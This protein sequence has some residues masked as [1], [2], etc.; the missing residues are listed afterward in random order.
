MDSHNNRKVFV[1]KSKIKKDALFLIDG[2]YFLYRSYFALPPLHTPDGKPTHATYAFCRTLNKIIKEYDPQQIA[3]VWDSKG[4]TQRK[5]EYEAYK[6]TR[7]EPPSDLFIQ[8]EDIIKFIELIN[9][10]S[11][12]KTGYEADDLIAS[13]AKENKDKQTV[14]I[15]ADKDMSQLL[16]DK[17]ILIID[18]FKDR[19]IDAQELKQEKGFDPE[20]VPF[21]FSLLGDSSDNIPGVKGVGKKTALDLVTQF[22]S[23]DDLYKNL[24]KIEK[25]RTQTLLED[26]KDNAYLS[27]KLFLLHTIKLGIKK[28]ELDFDKNNLAKA[29]NFF[30]DLGFKSLVKE[31]EKKH[32]KIQEL[33]QQEIFEKTKSNNWKLHVVTNTLELK[34][35][36]AQLKKDK[37][38]ALDT[39]TTGVNPLVHTLVGLS[40]ASNTK[41][42]FYVPLAHPKSERYA[43]VKFKE[44]LELLK[45]LFESKTI[46]KTLHH[47]KFDELVLYQY[48]IE[49]QG[50]DFDTIIAA[51]LLRQAWQK[52][53]LKDLSQKYLK[54]PMVKFKDIVKKKYKTFAEV[55]IEDGAEYGAHDALQ[56]L[57][58]KKVLEKDFE[59]EPALKKLFKTI[60]MPFHEVLLAMEKKGILLDPEILNATGEKITHK[61]KN[62]ETKIFAALPIGKQKISGKTINLNSPKQIEI[63]LF[64]YL[65]LPAP[66]ESA[67]GSR[68]TDREVLLELGKQHP[69]PNLIV[70]YRELAK[71]KN[72]YIDPLPKAINKK[73]KRIHTSF[74]QTMTATGRLSSSDPNLQNIPAYGDYGVAIREA[75]V[76]SHGYEFVSADYSQMQ[77]RI[78]AHMSG[79]KN[80]TNAF[81][82]NKD[83]H[84]QTAS[85]IFNIPEE[86]VT[87]EQR[88][89]GK[90]INFSVIY[91][92]TPYGLSKE[93]QVKP[94]VAKEFIQAYFE[95][96]PNVAQWIEKTIKTTEEHGYVESLWGRRRW[97][98]EIKEKNRARY[99]LG[100]RLA[101]NTPVQATEAD[102]MKIA[103]LNITQALHKEKLK[104]S[105]VLQIHDELILE[106][107]T[108][109]ISI[110]KKML[111][112]EMENVV[113]WP[114]S[115]TIDI[116]SGKNWGAIT[117]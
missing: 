14:I 73:T 32:T 47:A 84:V 65:G 35:L 7:P 63:L 106:V 13:L 117:K 36:I 48:G 27:Y 24:G 61:L 10:C 104:A 97:I 112:K 28:K 26:Q 90:R 3:I 74:S 85:Q 25:K 8:K 58:L 75:F 83:V 12:A 78:L 40:C 88:Q 52:I 89:I 22:D 56:T 39:E 33:H 102:I 50:V 5:K 99:E 2:S 34:A 92:Q 94:S 43:Q 109:E 6:A 116:R 62:I 57:K 66:R 67:K 108:K 49:L 21:Y 42:A 86:K 98:P 41:E 30:K 71:L 103:M 55:P 87:Q 53:N 37:Y 38:F 80:L 110:V 105:I 59:K 44:A 91:G 79:D 4:P 51:N 9:M 100:K 45:P 95:H 23:L 31:I 19:I 70:E 81:L 29:I 1:V 54:E 76:A 15:S 101:V 68:S 18:P 114:I 107:P 77:L 72:T 11:V 16:T 111:K 115:L 60:E 113:S 96:Y 82:G 69:V 93:L 64:E 17:N 20:K 46:K